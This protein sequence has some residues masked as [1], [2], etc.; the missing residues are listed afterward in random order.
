M[1]P[2]VVPMGRLKCAA[3]LVMFVMFV[4]T[5]GIGGV[6]LGVGADREGVE[7]RYIF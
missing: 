4:V 2:F 3:G 5:A 6:V 7:G 1:M